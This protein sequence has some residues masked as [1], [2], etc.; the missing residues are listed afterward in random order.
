MQTQVTTN[1]KH[2]TSSE[3]YKGFGK[4]AGA[5]CAA[6]WITDFF[7]S[8]S[9]VATEYKAAFSISSLAVAL[10]EA[11]VGGLVIALCVSFF[12]L[13]FS[14]IIPGK[15]PVFKTLFLSFIVMAIIEVASTLRDPAR[16]SVYLLLD[17]GM[18]MPRFLALGWVIG[19][20]FD[21]QKRK[22]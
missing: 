8:I 10:G 20:L 21:Q 11:F 4:L 16:A 12:L 3:F 18:N 9:P 6:F 22:V 14:S 17:T 2:Q 15:K 5:G 13:R 7:M 19:Y 1:S